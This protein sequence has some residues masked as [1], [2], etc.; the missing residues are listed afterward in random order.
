MTKFFTVSAFLL[1]LLMFF[2]LATNNAG[3]P[4][5]L[6]T[7]EYGIDTDAA[8]LDR[9]AERAHNEEMARIAA[10]EYAVRME[11]R[12]ILVLGMFGILGTALLGGAL[13]YGA[14]SRPQVIVRRLEDRAG[15]V[16]VVQEER[17]KLEA[18]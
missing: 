2:L 8:L 7:V 15:G 17:K 18:R 1:L 16:T 12:T 9:A 6:S 14:A 4:A 13:V 10:A 11:Y 5:V 3:N